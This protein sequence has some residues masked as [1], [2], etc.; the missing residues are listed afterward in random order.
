MPGPS[1]SMRVAQSQNQVLRQ[2]IVAMQ[3]QQARYLEMS[4]DGTEAWLSQQLRENPALRRLSPQP[5][6]GEVATGHAA[7][8]SDDEVPFDWSWQDNPDLQKHLMEQLQLERTGEAERRAAEV[9]IYNLDDK[10]FLAV[11]LE[12][13]AEQAGVEL[14]DA[15]DGQAVVM[16]L[17]PEGC[18]ASDVLAYLQ[19]KVRHQFKDD[20]RFPRLIGEYLDEFRDKNYRRIA[21]L[22]H[23]A[24]EDAEAYG[25]RLAEVPPFPAIG[26]SDGQKEHVTPTVKIER[27]GGDLK[28][29]VQEPPRARLAMN[30]VFEERAR[31]LPEGPEREAALAQIEAARLILSRMEHR[32]SLLYRVAEYAV[33]EQKAWFDHGDE[34]MKNLTMDRAAEYLSELRPNI[35]RTVKGRYC[36]FEGRVF[37]LRDLFTHRSKPGRVSKNKLHAMLRDI[38]AGEDKSEPLS[39]SQIVVELL[40]RG[41]REARRTVAK[42]RELAGIP[43]AA[44]RRRDPGT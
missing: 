3:A 41:V 2:I 26:F 25:R 5:R 15:E 11:T 30:K 38:V 35:S 9:I 37:P 27:V 43:A 44:R 22:A 40:R 7:P 21:K 20:K 39:D 29:E 23:I 31:S 36:L 4:E 28:V 13:I 32:T 19:F 12:E 34:A 10:G 42:H 1:L 16:D 24:E 33:R 18:G 17:E 8:M 14:D 6:G